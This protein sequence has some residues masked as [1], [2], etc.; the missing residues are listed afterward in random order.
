LATGGDTVTASSTAGRMS[1]EAELEIRVR[2]RGRDA[3]HPALVAVTSPDDDTEASESSTWP[4]EP[5]R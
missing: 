2:G 3:G 1:T 5:N 4:A